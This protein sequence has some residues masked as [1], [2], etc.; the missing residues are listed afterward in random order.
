MRAVVSASFVF[1]I[2]VGCSE[3]YVERPPAPANDGIYSFANGC[4]AMDGTPVGG[5][6]TRWI[7]ATGDASFAFDSTTQDGG[8]RFFLKPADLGTYLLYDAD[9]RYLVSEHGGIERTDTLQ[10]DLELLDDS[11]VSP[12]EWDLEVAASD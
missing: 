10:S 7:A 11:F 4:Y 3:P 8:A 6:N 1:L 9:G 12:A 2:S 5:T